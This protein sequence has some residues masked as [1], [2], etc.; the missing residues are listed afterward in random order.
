MSGVETQE[1]DNLAH[2]DISGSVGNPSDP[3][4]PPAPG[5][6]RLPTRRELRAAESAA[7]FRPR[8]DSATRT[9]QA[10]APRLT[11]APVGRS[12]RT[13][14]ANAV[15]MTFVT[16]LVG[17]MA[18]PAY[19]AGSQLEHT[20]SAEGVSLQDYSAA[21]A[22]VVT[23][24]NASSAPVEEEGFTATS[25]A[26]LSAQKAAAARAA[27]A[28]QRRTQLASSA[29][30]YTGESADQLAQNPIYQGTSAS[31]VS[32]VARQYLG[33]PYVF[34]GETPAGFDCSG[35]VK[36]VFAQF[37]LNLPHSVR[38][39]HNAGTVVSREDARPGDIVVWNDFSH[40][41]IYTGNGIFIDA[42]KPGDHVK[43]RPIWSTN[44]HF[45]RLLG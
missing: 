14:A 42:P 35:L 8:R 24:D 11:P 38:A 23:A 21:N 6:D 5:M 26:E 13:K 3:T 19:A 45:V 18:I 20:T 40:D 12:R 7:A 17:V 22:Q 32:A 16:G 29:T 44:V 34:G 30:S 4:R 37:G 2:G 9:L 1:V 41:G 28:E 43:E 33:V 15:V 31:G 36:Y 27:L 10:P 25:V 39:Q